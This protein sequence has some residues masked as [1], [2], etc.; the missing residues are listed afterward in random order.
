MAVYQEPLPDPFRRLLA[1]AAVCPLLGYSDDRSGRYS[2]PT[3]LH[4][5]FAVGS[6]QDVSL[7]Q[8]RS[9]CFTDRYMQCP[10]LTASFAPHA[11]ERAVPSQR[12]RPTRVD[13]PTAPRRT[14]S[15]GSGRANANQTPPPRSSEE[16]APYR[17]RSAPR[18]VGPRIHLVGASSVMLGSLAYL[19]VVLAAIEADPAVGLWGLFSDVGWAQ[20]EPA[21]A[22]QRAHEQE[23]AALAAIQQAGPAGLAL[24][25][26]DEVLDATARGL[27]TADDTS[28]DLADDASAGELMGWD[29]DDAEDEAAAA[30]DEELA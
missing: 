22:A 24:S 18:P 23:V 16:P 9:R 19:V 3:R 21:P 6:A 28:T 29:D 2:R 17:L 10:R 8:Q 11:T 7:S 15:V 1:A 5:C 26:D 12:S 13:Q 4:G 27:P 20:H 30:E 25:L 14:Q